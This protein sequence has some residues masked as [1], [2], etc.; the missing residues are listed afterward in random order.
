[1]NDSEATR[2][3]PEV[4]API[5][6]EQEPVKPHWKQT[7]EGK[8]KMQQIRRHNQLNIKK[9]HDSNGRP[10]KY[11]PKYKCLTCGIELAD[12]YYH[13]KNYE[14]HRVVKLSLEDKADF[15][16][17]P[18]RA[19][20]KKENLNGN[21]ITSGTATG[22]EIETSISYLF[23]RFEEQLEKFAIRNQ[24]SEAVLAGGVSA[25]FRSKAGGG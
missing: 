2:T 22:S 20:I 14:G 6:A 18:K 23:G 1:M 25:L 13:L 12:K 15:V 10:T 17:K 3:A 9:Y 11:P 21:A 5:E 8:I 24:L 19:Y 7:P 16:P 4:E